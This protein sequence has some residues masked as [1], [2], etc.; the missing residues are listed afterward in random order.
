MVGACGASG[1]ANGLLLLTLLTC[2]PLGISNDV[3]MQV[4]A[5]GLT[6]GVIQGSMETASNSPTDTLFVAVVDLGCGC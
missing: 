2:S 5:A 6:I 4:V 1:V 3:T